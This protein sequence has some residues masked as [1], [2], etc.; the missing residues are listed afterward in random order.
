[1]GQP[2]SVPEGSV[3]EFSVTCL[4]QNVSFLAGP[5]F[6]SLTLVPCGSRR[7]LNWLFWRFRAGLERHGTSVRSYTASARVGIAITL[8]PCWTGRF[9]NRAF[10]V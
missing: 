3:L 4:G 1:M 7:L 10:L 5:I 2:R 9:L 6:I 8:G